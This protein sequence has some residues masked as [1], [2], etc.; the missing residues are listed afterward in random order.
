LDVFDSIK[1]SSREDPAANAARQLLEV[2][3]H[4]DGHD[5]GNWGWE[6]HWGSLRVRECQRYNLLWLA[7]T[8]YDLLL[9]TEPVSLQKHNNQ[10]DC[11]SRH[12]DTTSYFTSTSLIQTY[13]YLPSHQYIGCQLPHLQTIHDYTIYSMPQSA[14][15]HIP[16]NPIPSHPFLFVSLCYH[17]SRSMQEGT[18]LGTVKSWQLV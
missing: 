13:E 5:V 3:H 12:T 7:M 15:S 16:S 9:W 8:C 10:S 4:R 18:E 11:E 1:R 17:W 2:A 6:D 14:A